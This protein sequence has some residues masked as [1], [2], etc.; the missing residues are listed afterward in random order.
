MKTRI[1]IDYDNLSPS[2]KNLGVKGIVQRVLYLDKFDE[3]KVRGECVIR[4]Y[5]GWYE[6]KNLTGAAEKL[7]AEIGATFPTI[8]FARGESA[9]QLNSKAELAYSM[10]EAPKEHLFGTYR[11]KQ[12]PHNIRCTS[13]ADLGCADPACPLEMLKKFLHTRKC[14]R[15]KCDCDVSTFLYRNEQKLVDTMLTC[16]ILYSQKI[17]PNEY[18]YVISSDDDI[19][20]AIKTLGIRGTRVVRVLTKTN[21]NNIYTGETS[22]YS[23]RSIV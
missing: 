13:P 16:D 12:F 15:D 6:D 5:G 20:P 7:I 2:Q 14:P 21:I 17:F 19:L 8:L 23:E 11:K 9:I 22:Q 18:V 3:V 4:L 10:S 1:F